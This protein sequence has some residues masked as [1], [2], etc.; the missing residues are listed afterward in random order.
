ME[1]AQLLSLLALGAALEEVLAF[2]EADSLKRCLCS[3]LSFPWG[4]GDASSFPRACSNGFFDGLYTVG[5]HIQRYI[6]VCLA[7]VML[8]TT[9][10]PWLPPDRFHCFF[11]LQFLWYKKQRSLC[12]LL[13][14]KGVCMS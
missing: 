9:A 13:V 11:V 3:F 7:R 4:P 1:W 14:G 6:C 8:D 10:V 2:R 5:W 12:R